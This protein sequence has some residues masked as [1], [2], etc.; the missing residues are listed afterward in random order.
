MIACS[1]FRS[2]QFNKRAITLPWIV[3][4]NPFPI[5]CRD[6]KLRQTSEATAVVLDVRVDVCLVVELE[7]E[8]DEAVC[9]FAFSFFN[10]KASLPSRKDLKYSAKESSFTDKGEL[11]AVS[12]DMLFTIHSAYPRPFSKSHL[13]VPESAKLKFKLA[14]KIGSIAQISTKSSHLT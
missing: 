12:L 4:C 2:L 13:K 3:R 6:N 10:A 5:S 1:C 9:S 14:K 8:V 7:V 11:E